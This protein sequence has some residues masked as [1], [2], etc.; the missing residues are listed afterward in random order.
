M[1]AMYNLKRLGESNTMAYLLSLFF[2]LC[3]EI[4]APLISPIVTFKL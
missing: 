4:L 3:V 2:A 1:N